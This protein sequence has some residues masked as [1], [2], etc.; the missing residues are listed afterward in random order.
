MIRNGTARAVTLIVTDY[1][2][3]R[4]IGLTQDSIRGRVQQRLQSLDFTALPEDD[5][6][7]QWLYVGIN[8]VGPA[9]NIDVSFH[10]KTFYLRVNRSDVFSPTDPDFTVLTHTGETWATGSV[11]TH[12]GDLN[13]VLNA[14]EGHVDEFL[15]QY[16]ASNQP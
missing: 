9:Y 8:G 15:N 13:F 2:S 6:S 3:L 16:L 11:G 1:T 7:P 4:E 12:G 10:R 14:V 5:A